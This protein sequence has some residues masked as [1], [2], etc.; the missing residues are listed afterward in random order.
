MGSHD[1]FTAS[2]HQ[3]KLCQID[4]ECQVLFLGYILFHEANICL[5]TIDIQLF[6]QSYRADGV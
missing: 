2:P 5:K 1:D 3:I 6:Q 4:L